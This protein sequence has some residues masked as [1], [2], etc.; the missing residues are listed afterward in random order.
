MRRA[1]HSRFTTAMLCF[2]K[3][4]PLMGRRLRR[5]EALQGRSTSRWGRGGGN[6]CKGFLFPILLVQVKGLVVSG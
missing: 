6:E 3:T 1:A 2:G 4:F 5:D